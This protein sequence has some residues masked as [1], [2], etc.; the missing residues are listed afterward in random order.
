MTHRQSARKTPI[1]TVRCPICQKGVTREGPGNHFHREHK[2]YLWHREKNGYYCDFPLPGGEVCGMSFA[3]FGTGKDSLLNHYAEVHKVKVPGLNLSTY[4][5][6]NRTLYCPICGNRCT[7]KR[8]G[9]GPGQHYHEEHKEFRWHCEVTN[10]HRH[11]HCD[12]CGAPFHS[13]GVDKK[14][15]L[16]HYQTDH[17]EVI[18]H[19][20]IRVGSEGTPQPSPSIEVDKVDKLLEQVNINTGLFAKEQA[21]NRRLNG[22]LEDR[23]RRVDELEK[24][25]DMLEK[26]CVEYA[27]RIVELQNQQ[28]RRDGP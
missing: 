2:E 19:L 6:P 28:I 16:V 11:Y 10:G 7:R 26:K 12:L 3:G 4:T 24:T 17:K 14:S 8:N 22:L 1:R 25:A 13:F 27:T 5:T 20:K 9:G 15:L 21:E 23:Q 18:A